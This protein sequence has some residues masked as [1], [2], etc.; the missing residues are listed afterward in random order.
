MTARAVLVIVLVIAGCASHRTAAPRPDPHPRRPGVEARSGERRARRVVLAPRRD[1]TAQQR[2]ECP[3][4]PDRS[5]C[6]ALCAGR[7]GWEWC[8]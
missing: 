6:R 1:P 5:D 3:I 2:L 4:D 8:R 7:A